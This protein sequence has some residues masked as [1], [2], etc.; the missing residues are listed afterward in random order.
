MSFAELATD[1]GDFLC[2]TAVA[3]TVAVWAWFYLSR[4]AAWAFVFAYLTTIVTTTGLKLISI[5]ALPPLAGA[6]PMTLSQGAPSG[7]MALA[8]VVY[9]T[10]AL[11][12]GKAGRDWRGVL[13]QVL[14]VA[15]IACVGFTRVELRNHTVADVL[16]GLV[17]GGLALS[18]PA[19]VLRARPVQGRML[20]GRLIS[21]MAIVD[22]MFLLS[23]IRMPS[24]RFI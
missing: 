14:C 7:H 21:T 4:L 20:L 15:V 13:G 16:A 12:C 18:F 19:M 17:M 1:Q 9:G 2:A 5:Q 6:A 22:A 8:T 24:S 3:V 23:G 10:A 11:F